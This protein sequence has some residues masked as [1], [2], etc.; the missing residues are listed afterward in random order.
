MSSLRNSMPDRKGPIEL[1]TL[2]PHA[3]ASDWPGAVLNVAHSLGPSLVS[4]TAIAG[5]LGV[6]QNWVAGVRRDLQARGGWPFARRRT[7]LFAVDLE[8][9]LPPPPT[10]HDIKVRTC[11]ERARR[12]RRALERI[13]RRPDDVGRILKHWKAERRVKWSARVRVQVQA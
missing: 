3:G 9:D 2:P 12:L 4:D 6:H 10:A 7:N 1:P 8:A 13:R 11:V 5:R